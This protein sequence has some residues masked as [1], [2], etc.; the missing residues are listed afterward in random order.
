M[1]KLLIGCV[2]VGI[3]G[4]GLAAVLRGP[5]KKAEAPYVVH[6]RPGESL[7][8]VRNAVRALPA[9]NRVHGVEVRL[10]PGRYTLSRPLALGAAD[11]GTPEAPVV[12]RSDDGG[13]AV[14]CDGVSLSAS[15]FAP[16]TD[17]AVR[18][19]LDA[20]ARDAVRV[21]DLS[22]CGLSFWKPL[23][24]ER[25][26]PLPIPELFCDGARMTPAEWPNDGEWATIASFV[27]E[28]TR[29][30]DG[31]VS[32]GLGVKRDEKASPPRGG[33][34]GYAGDRPA[35][36]TKAREV[37]L[38]GFWCFDWHDAVLPVAAINA[39]SNTITLA[40]QHTYGIRLG[41]PSPR[42]WKAIHVLEELDVPGEYYVDPVAKKLYFWPPRALGPAA[43]VTLVEANR[44]LVRVEKAHDLVFRGLGFE[45][46]GGDAAVVKGC[47]AVA[48]ERCDFRNVKG[49]AIA[50]TDC[51]ACRVTTCDI[52]ETGAGGV[53]V[54]GGD[55]RSLTPGGNV[56]EDTR[57]RNFSVLRR[58]YASAVQLGGVGNVVRHCEL[59]GAPHMAVGVS[60]NDHVF[61]YNVVSNVC[62]SSDDAAAFYKGRDPSCRGNVL[63]YN[64]WSEIGSPRGHGNAAIYF[65]DGDGGDLV[66]GN[67]FYRCGEPGLGG[68]GAVF[69]HGG[70]SNVV[71]NCVFVQCRRPL[72]SSPW[73]QARWADFLK[74]P[75]IQRRLLEDVCVTGRV[76][77]ARYPALAGIFAPEGDDARWNAAF[78]NAFVEC[79]LTLPGRKPGET[80]PGLVCGRWR[81]NAT[82]VVFAADPGFVDAAAK[83]FALRPDAA[84]FR[85][86]PAFKPIPFEKIGL[87][88]RR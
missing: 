44:P 39:A 34:F 79:P 61:E 87:A 6:A 41:N 12:W 55:R 66:Y 76:W 46:C 73:K 85:R 17:A 32:Q 75:L 84:L 67:V 31:T 30:N 5:A 70:H 33:T 82:D 25:R 53:A 63:R 11:G 24:R 57:I 2:A 68:F 72:G 81:T 27:D 52:Q 43:R 62:M 74:S 56:V 16:V 77:R 60:G 13:R 65:D 14:L 19:R 42:R 36:W 20:A 59:S 3:C 1:K 69:S 35:R 10:A 37:W 7:E 40:A 49:K 21:A 29:L 22:A 80:R 23:T 26:L 8:A 78:D 50:M 64:F 54:S 86:L 4:I 28:G 71:Q 88:T 18:D 83:N 38:Y 48:F 58:T 45:L 51:R 9:S 47:A 15:A